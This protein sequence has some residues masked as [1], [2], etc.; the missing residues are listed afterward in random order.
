[1]SPDAYIQMVIQLAYFKIYGTCTAT[2][3]T[4]QT[5]KFFHGRT[6]TVRTLSNASKKFVSGMEDTNLSVRFAPLTYGPHC[7]LTLLLFSLSVLQKEKKFEILK[8][9]IDSHVKYMSDASEGKGV[10]RHL[11]G[12]MM[13]SREKN[14]P[15]PAIFSDPS[16]GVS[17]HFR[18]STS[19]LT[20]GPAFIGGFGPVVDDGYGVCYA[21]RTNGCWFSVS[22]KTTCHT[23]DTRQMMRA[24]TASLNEMKALCLSLKKP[25]KL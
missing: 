15:L 16:Y 22:S 3:E 18:L 6:E 4:A 7:F 2:Y 17:R 8:L 5:R 21:L 1:M 9:A 23:T 24:L 14:E 10:D 13:C 19:N 20:P 12:L 11:L 25:A